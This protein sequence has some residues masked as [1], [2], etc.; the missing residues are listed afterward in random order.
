MQ[1]TTS[2]PSTPRLIVAGK[3]MWFLI[4]IK[5]RQ[6]QLLSFIQSR[7]WQLLFRK[8]PNSFTE[9][10]FHFSL[11]LTSI[12]I[13]DMSNHWANYKHFERNQVFFA[14][15]FSPAASP[16][17]LTQLTKWITLCNHDFQNYFHC[18]YIKINAKIQKIKPQTLKIW[19]Q[20]RHHLWLANVVKMNVKRDLK[21]VRK[22][23]KGQ[24]I[25]K[26]QEKWWK[27]CKTQPKITLPCFQL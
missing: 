1:L 3:N 5:Y 15:I 22:S 25:A 7:E 26:W 4:G 14:A 9:Q 17:F 19:M 11:G 16:S 21:W 2:L 27:G 10:L 12:N 20:M 8:N 13:M 24:T 6:R 18:D 23:K